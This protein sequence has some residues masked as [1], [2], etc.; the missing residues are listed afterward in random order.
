MLIV[1]RVL[2]AV[3]LA[4]IGA[5]L[6]YS[7]PQHDVV[8]IVG[9][10][11]KRIDFDEVPWWWAAP[12][13]GTGEGAGSRDVR[14][15]NAAFPG[16]DGASYVYRNEDTSW[17]FPPYF[18]FDS[19]TLTAD[20]QRLVSTEADPVWVVVTHYGWRFELFTMFPNAV[21]IRRA[22]GPDETVVPWFSIVFLAGLAA[23]V[24]VVL[25]FL[26]RLRA[27]HVDPVV[28]R[29]GDAIE[30]AAERVD[31]AYDGAR[32]K[33]GGIWERFDR[34]LDTWRPRA[35]KKYRGR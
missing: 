29:V 4:I 13:A 7:L 11:V 32:A 19:S 5:V 31:G 34:W 35:R 10:E 23:L 30:D 22:S 20:A 18:K 16:E 2:Q 33:A 25:R 21:D 9:T 6:H 15:I 26:A 17:G 3:V 14:F 1:K 28:A 12:D 27:R 8:R 24:A